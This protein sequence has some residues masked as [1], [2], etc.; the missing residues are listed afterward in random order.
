MQSHKFLNFKE[1]CLDLLIINDWIESIQNLYE[2][3]QWASKFIILFPVCKFL[4]AA[5][6]I[7]TKI[8]L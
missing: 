8:F 4:S 3:P 1:D 7:I 5:S 6:V 2:I